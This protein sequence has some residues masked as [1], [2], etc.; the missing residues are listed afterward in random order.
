[1]ARL[2]RLQGSGVKKKPY[3]RRPPPEKRANGE[4]KC[5]NVVL[6]GKK[7]RRA[8]K[9][10]ACVVAHGVVP[11][12]LVLASIAGRRVGLP[13]KKNAAAQ[14]HGAEA[15]NPTTSPTKPGNQPFLRVATT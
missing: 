3:C 6:I 13:I 2:H 7:L 11:R 14:T 5:Q 10:S 12:A 8:S 9:N 15:T 4:K 1:M